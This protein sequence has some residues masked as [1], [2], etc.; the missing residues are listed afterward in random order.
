MWFSCGNYFLFL[1]HSMSLE[2]SLVLNFPFW[3]I[4]NSRKR[5]SGVLF[6]SLLFFPLWKGW[7][8]LKL[9]GET[10]WQLLEWVSCNGDSPT[11]CC[12]LSA[13]AREMTMGAGPLL[14]RKENIIY[15]HINWTK[16]KINKKNFSW[17]PKLM[18]TGSL[19]LSFTRGFPLKTIQR[20]VMMKWVTWCCW[21]QNNHYC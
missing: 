10:S 4:S 14:N 8:G 3:H 5:N 16:C 7:A 1:S 17:E 21:P 9:Q 2:S 18:D 13:G 6:L 11:S 20:N 19:P 12:H 15:H